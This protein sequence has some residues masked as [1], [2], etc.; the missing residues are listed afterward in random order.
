MRRFP[1]S[2]LN[3]ARSDPAPNT[4]LSLF[5][6]AAL[7]KVLEETI[8]PAFTGATGTIVE[9]VFEP[10]SM[11]LRRIE[12]GARPG[13][14]L[15]ITGTLEASAGPGVFEL[16]SSKP[17]AKS[18]IGVAVPANASRPCI[19]SVERLVSVLT[20]ARS[21]AY[22]RAGPS[23]IYF[24]GLLRELGIAEQVDARST[25]VDDG[26]VACAL[27][28]GRSDLAIQ[29]MCELMFVPGATVIGHLPDAVQHFTEF[30]ATLSGKAAN[31][32]AASALFD[33]LT[34]ALA[35]SAYTS[36]GLEPFQ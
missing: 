19:A 25:I 18:G 35:V 12:A 3:L 13:I 20:T 28:D 9:V 30:S 26:P 11:L 33:F 17:V 21:V 32:V 31:D 23:G 34:G 1:S 10:T 36:G 2:P 8:L 5:C 24:S 15:G 29:Q 27:I 6:A 16:T 7:R 22:S 14:F 4:T